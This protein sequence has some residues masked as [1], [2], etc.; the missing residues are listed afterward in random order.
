MFYRSLWCATVLA[1]LLVLAG[2]QRGGFADAPEESQ[3]AATKRFVAY[4]WNVE[5]GRYENLVATYWL[6]G[7]MIDPQRAKTATDAMPDGH[8]VLLSWD[9]HR[10]YHTD[11]RD[12]CRDA[13][14]N[15][16]GQPGIWWE[17]GVVE[18]AARF[19]D[20]FGR[21]KSIGGQV[22]AVVLDSEVNLSNW[23]LGRKEQRYR[24]IMADPRFDPIAKQLGFR[25]LLT[26]MNWQ[27]Q[28]GPA[29]DH[30][31]IWNALM[32]R[33]VVDY[34]NRAV[35][36]PIGKH[37]PGVKLSNWGGCYN[38]PEFACPDLNGHELSRFSPGAHV[39]THQSGH[40]YCEIAQLS[41]R[42]FHGG[43]QPYG[44]SP[45]AGF[46]LSVNRMRS[47]ALSSDVPVWPWISHKQYRDS[48]VR[49]SGLYQELIF[50]AGLCG[51]DA[52]LL[53]NPRRRLATQQ[54]EHFADD[55]QDKLVDDC[56][57]QL[58]EL[59]G[60]ADQKTLVTGLAG[61]YDDYVLTGMQA[62]GRSV[63][64]FTPELEP[65]QTWQDTLTT[66]SPPTFHTGTTTIRIPNGTVHRPREELSDEG[67]WIT[68]PADA[69]PVISVAN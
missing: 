19:D 52:F 61:W 31:R 56:L 8:R 25:D 57:R 42:T 5:P 11:P 20:F 50:H 48:R 24:A 6:A 41:R 30:F 7:R 14:G 38:A 23:A 65:G 32:H 51:P 68:A 64:R 21:Y 69:R 46:R 35:Y 26:V 13:A 39:G 15:P 29:Q 40:L 33:R 16:T 67:V 22:D 18:I 45:F 43:R 66:A 28:S 2:W 27:Q 37:Y 58:N 44:D 62:G 49:A 63:W 9:L 10:W 60:T 59:V 53:W 4:T 3:T 47:M 34:V 12:Y 36:E 17:H 54:P 55:A 1:L